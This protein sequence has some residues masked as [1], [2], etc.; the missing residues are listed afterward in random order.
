MD[1]LTEMLKEMQTRNSRLDRQSFW[2][3]SNSTFSDV[4]YTSLPFSSTNHQVVMKNINNTIPTISNPFTIASILFEKET[5]FV[6]QLAKNINS[7]VDPK[8]QKIYLHVTQNKHFSDISRKPDMV[9]T[10]HSTPPTSASEIV[11]WIE[12]KINDDDHEGKGQLI[13]GLVKLAKKA[14]TRRTLFYGAIINKSH[15]KL[16]QFTWQEN[17]DPEIIWTEN[18]PWGCKLGLYDAHC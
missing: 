17:R 10:S 14:Q 3:L 6:S 2:M 16:M 5:E 12:L 15:I 11:V 13:S 1:A 7:N 4:Y 8:R 9:L 18:T